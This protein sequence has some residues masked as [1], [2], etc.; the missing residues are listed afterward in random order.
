MNLTSSV[1]LLIHSRLVH[2]FDVVRRIKQR[3]QEVHYLEGQPRHHGDESHLHQEVR[4][5]ILQVKVLAQE[6]ERNEVDHC[7][8]Y[9]HQHHSEGQSM[10]L[11]VNVQDFDHYQG[12]E[13]DHHN[14][15]KRVMEH[16][17]A[18]HEYGRPLEY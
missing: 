1:Y 7:T 10:D 2:D 15:C 6:D 17:K 3:H 11:R 4:V 16:E 14:I 5:E 12:S 13:S 18:H 8:R 9:L